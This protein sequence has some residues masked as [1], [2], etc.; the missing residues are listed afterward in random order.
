MPQTT[1]EW[2][3]HPDVDVINTPLA[4]LAEPATE[5][6]TEPA[7]STPD[8]DWL[9]A[10]KDHLDSSITSTFCADAEVCALRAI[11]AALIDIANTLKLQDR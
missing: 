10:A 7:A 1:T 8:V 4:D 6:A 9:Y 3:R 11:A 5:P 2:R